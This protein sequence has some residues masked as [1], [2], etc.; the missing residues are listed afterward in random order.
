MEINNQLF[1]LPLFGAQSLPI[2]KKK[3]EQKEGMSII[4]L[5]SL[6]FWLFLKFKTSLLVPLSDLNLSY[7]SKFKPKTKYPHMKTENSSPSPILPRPKWENTQNFGKMGESP[8]KSSL[9][10]HYKY[11]NPLQSL[12]INSPYPSSKHNH[13]NQKWRPWLSVKAR[14]KRTSLLS[15]QSKPT[16]FLESPHL[17]P[18]LSG[19]NLGSLLLTLPTSSTPHRNQLQLQ[20]PRMALNFPHLQQSVHQVPERE[21]QREILIRR[22]L[23]FSRH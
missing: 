9:Q 15:L 20:L 7:T 23:H 22:N 17:P 16:L 8:F 12:F 2:W 6:L 3:S 11:L 18:K 4:L 1:W 10:Q 21:K 14:T 5:N 13:H 19:E